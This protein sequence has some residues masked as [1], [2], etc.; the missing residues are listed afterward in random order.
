[1]LAR[2]PNLLSVLRLG[3]AIAFPWSPPLWRAPIVIVAGFT[4]WLDGFIARN[5]GARSAN[6][7]LLDAVADKLFALSV[8]LTLAGTAEITWWQMGLVIAR[9]LAVLLVAIYVALRRRWAA[10]RRL[11]PR[12]PGKV[13]TGCQF[14]FFLAMLLPQAG[15][16]V[17]TGALWVTVA[18][19]LLAAADYLRQF[20]LA[21]REDRL[22]GPPGGE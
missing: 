19:S 13:T 4:D 6:G 3:L 11:V 9:D 1:M 2:V 5:F 21:L 14:A 18:C 20:A 16:A 22:G 7:A 17:R 8:L 10:F 12:V 15:P